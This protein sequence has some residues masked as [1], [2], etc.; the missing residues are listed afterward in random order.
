MLSFVPLRSADFDLYA[1]DL[2]AIL[3]DNMNEIAPSG[4]SY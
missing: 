1:D 4:C 2:F 3:W